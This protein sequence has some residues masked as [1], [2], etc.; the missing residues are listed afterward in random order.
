MLRDL[1]A[2]PDPRNCGRLGN[3]ARQALVADA[4]HRSRGGADVELA[5]EVDVRDV[6]SVLRNGAYVRAGPE[7]S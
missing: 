5:A 3:A 6:E 7:R 1:V 4:P 2:A